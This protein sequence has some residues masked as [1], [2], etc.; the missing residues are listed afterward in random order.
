[1]TFG[2][3]FQTRSF[4]RFVVDRVVTVTILIGNCKPEFASMPY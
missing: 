3:L 1:M 4:D 2:K